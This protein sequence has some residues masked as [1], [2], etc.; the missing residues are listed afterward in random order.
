MIQYDISCIEKCETI[1]NVVV[2]VIIVVDVMLSSCQQLPY[3]KVNV[4]TLHMHVV[5][6]V[7]RSR[8]DIGWLN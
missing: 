5:M 7:Y 1:N 2:T 8:I 3:K 4:K 6:Y